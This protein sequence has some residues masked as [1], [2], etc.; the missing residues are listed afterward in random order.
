MG[1]TISFL[2]R[3][4][5]E[6]KFSNLTN[7]QLIILNN[8][9]I[10]SIDPSTFRGLTN[11]QEISLCDNQITSID[12][13][14]F[15]GLTNLQKISLYDNQITSIHP[16]TFRGLTNLQGIDL[17]F[18]QITFLNE[19]LFE[20]LTKLKK[21]ELQKNKFKD[22][23]LKLILEASVV[24]V[25]ILNWYSNEIKS[26]LNTKLESKTTEK[27]E[28]EDYDEKDDSISS[29]KR[30]FHK[31]NE[32]NEFKLDKNSVFKSLSVELINFVTTEPL[33][34]VKLKIIFIINN[35]INIPKYNI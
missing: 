35:L 4:I 15:N 21:I 26:I 17:K 31:N 22:N 8:K 16:S 12:P 29:D 10:T 7:L 33:Q 1:N 28:K 32:T 19:N 18:N 25:S 3:Q 2:N 14:T 9:Q 5:L 23:Q 27:E 34:K 24:S 30:E 6:K 20:G 11:L 13:S